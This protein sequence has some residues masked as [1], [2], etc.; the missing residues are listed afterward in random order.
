M[1][2]TSPPLSSAR[3]AQALG[4]EL[5]V[6]SYNVRYFGHA[7]RG[8]ASTGGA[9]RRIAEQIV[10]LD[11]LPDVIAL[12]EVETQSFRS[13]VANPREHPE[14]TQLDRMAKELDRALARRG[15]GTGFVACYFPAHRY[16]LGRGRTFTY[17]TTGLA[18]L[19]REGLEVERHNAL[20]PFDITHR[21]GI[22]RAGERPSRVREFLV[23]NLKQTRIC[24][25][26][27]VRHPSG[28]SLDVF[29][30]HFSLPSFFSKPFWT[31]ELRMG[32]GPNQLEEARRLAEFVEREQRSGRFVLMGDFNSLPGSPVD[33]FFREQG[34][35]DAYRAL[36]DVGDEEARRWPT[37]GFMHL[38]MHIDRMY[39]SQGVTFRDLDGTHPFGGGGPFAGLS[40]HVPLIARLRV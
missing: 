22:D 13:N 27:V 26:L 15:L 10:G 34:L 31:G 21:F 33:R 39:G 37:A 19:V 9:F 5:R 12:Q 8:L 1:T 20:E 40:D 11:P 3:A 38:R 28:A 18:I 14:E 17:Y 16:E 24:A 30:T 6:M 36:Y 4:A 23:R 2:S 29:N 35:V 25:H 7:T 32:F